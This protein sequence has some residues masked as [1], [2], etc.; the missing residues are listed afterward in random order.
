MDIL[1]IVAVFSLTIYGP[2]LTWKT[3]VYKD[4][5]ISKQAFLGILLLPSLAV[6]LIPRKSKKEKGK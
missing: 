3:N 6:F 5:G 1:F 4:W 2:N